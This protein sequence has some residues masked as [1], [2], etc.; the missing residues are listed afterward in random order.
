MKITVA[1]A[2]HAIAEP[3][4]FADFAARVSASVARAASAGTHVV[5]LPEYLALEAAAALAAGE[6]KVAAGAAPTKTVSCVRR[7]GAYSLSTT[8]RTTAGR[9]CCGQSALMPTC[10]SRLKASS[11]PR[12]SSATA[13]SSLP[14]AA[15]PSSGKPRSTGV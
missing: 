13:H 1:A 3:A 11:A 4:T 15:T 9:S 12:S 2:A 10:A 14:R 8:A 7:L 5:V 6:I